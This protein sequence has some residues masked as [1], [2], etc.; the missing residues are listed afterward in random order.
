MDD[1]Q[2]QMRIAAAH[3][4]HILT[5]T[6]TTDD[7]RINRNENVTISA[8]AARRRNA[9]NSVGRT[10]GQI[11]QRKGTGRGTV[12][13]DKD[14]GMGTN[15]DTNQEEPSQPFVD[16]IRSE[17]LT[18]CGFDTKRQGT[19]QKDT[20]EGRFRALYGTSSLAAAKLHRDLHQLDEAYRIGKFKL[21][22]FFMTLYW[23]KA[24]PTY[25]HF[26]AFWSTRFTSIGDVLKTYVKAIQQL[27]DLKIQ[28]FEEGELDD[29]D[30][31]IISVDGVHCRVR[32]VRKDPGTKWYSHK[33]H[34]A[35]LTYEL[36]IAIRQNRLV[37]IKGPYPASKNDLTIFRCGDGDKNNPQP[38]LKDKIPDG[39]RAI[40]DSI[41]RPE[42][43]K[44][45]SITRR[46]DSTAVKEFKARAKSR[47]ETFNRRIKSFH[48]L[49]TEFR[50]DISHHQ[51]V[52]EA[53]CILCQYDIEN[54][55]GLFEV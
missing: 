34:G 32:E 17:G 18:F 24:Y 50:H 33:S 36:A 5:V 9:A 44:T 42:D 48:I 26:E 46:G 31:F 22:Y 47:Q 51:M 29:D 52:M 23:L 16:E 20:T 21:K 30:I 40:A 4:R 55:H 25:I 7:R 11:D 39:K 41:Y 10:S 2:R 45:V 13:T 6:S 27:K 35:A 19:Y 14:T 1:I 38:A 43:G 53:V 49:A 37:S 15:T 54:G 12:P 3:R 8:A 28:W